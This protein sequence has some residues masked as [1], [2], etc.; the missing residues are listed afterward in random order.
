MEELTAAV[1]QVASGQAP[2][3]DGLPTDFYKHFWR[4]LGADLW[5]ALQEC[6]QT[7]LQYYQHLVG[8]RLFKTKERRLGAVKEPEACGVALHRLQ[9]SFSA[10]QQAQELP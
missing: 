9:C 3:L 7:G 4:C 10:R 1:G 8:T 6:P 5:G 2:G